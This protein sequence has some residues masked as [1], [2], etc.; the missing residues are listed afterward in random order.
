[1]GAE[2]KEE[3]QKIFRVYLRD[4]DDAFG[5]HDVVYMADDESR[6]ELIAYINRLLAI[7]EEGGIVLWP[8]PN[9]RGIRGN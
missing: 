9:N 6:T 4:L 7:I 3:E 2:K 5:G 8:P 1:M